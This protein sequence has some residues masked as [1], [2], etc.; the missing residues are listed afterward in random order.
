MSL[1]VLI[2]GA[3]GHAKVLI[4]ALL[5]ASEVIAGVVDPDTALTGTTVLEVPVLG[6]DEVVGEFPPDEILL[7]N[8]IG[9]VSPPV[10]RKQIFE[11]FKGMGYRFAMVIHPSVVVAADVEL[12]EGAQLMAGVVIQSGCRI[13]DNVIVNT[14]ASLDH[15][16][17]IGDHVHIAPGVTMSGG[18]QVGKGVHVGTGATI[19]QGISIGNDCLIAAGAVV[20]GSLR[21]GSRVRGVPAR[22]FV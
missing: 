8:G 20:V 22:E 10:M 11:R 18:V 12:G 5:A 2:L 3:G 14:R 13:G 7:V 17:Q 16:C 4:D 21:T 15:D 9:S 1:P 19:I 6:G